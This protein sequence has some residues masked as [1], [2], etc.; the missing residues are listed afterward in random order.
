MLCDNDHITA[1]LDLYAIVG[2]DKKSSSAGIFSRSL[3]TGVGYTA[4]T[5]VMVKFG[6][7]RNVMGVND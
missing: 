6:F 1:L 3:C 5:S 7:D 2:A 4:V